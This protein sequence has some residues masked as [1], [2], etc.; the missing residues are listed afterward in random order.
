MN[1][2]TFDF[3]GTFVKYCLMNSRAEISEHG[4][5]PAPLKTKEDFLDLI[6]RQ[7]EQYKDKTDGIA[8]SMPGVIDSDSG[9]IILVTLYPEMSGQNI[10]G[11]LKDRIPVPVSVENDG[12][13]AILAEA[14]KGALANVNDAVCILLGSGIGGGIIMGGKLQ[15]GYG[16][17]AGEISDLLVEPGR[18]EKENTICYDASMTGFL[19]AVARAKNMDPACFEISG[20]V[21]SS[22]K[23]ITGMDV[24]QWIE[25]EDPL[26]LAEYRNWIRRL[27]WMIYNLKLTVSPEKIVIGGGVSRN[28]RFIHDLK[29]EYR[30]A[31]AKLADYLPET[32]IDTC[33]F[34]A[35][36][37]LV[38]A[39]YNWFLM[40]D[41][42]EYI[43]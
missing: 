36:A 40:H 21:S 20:N 35:D 2:L 38:G 10:Y 32:A 13:A 29:E 15:K 41:E 4:Q 23:R 33:R 18:Y 26:T 3:G 30:E 24:F 27:V 42:R 7:Y 17:A 25:E 34:Q 16:F 31:A 5:L 14:W 37:N 22:E 12:K 11:L 39:A 8:I 28:E 19:K 43:S 9:E 1:L 6:C